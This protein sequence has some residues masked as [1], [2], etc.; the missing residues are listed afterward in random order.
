[1]Q[2]RFLCTPPCSSLVSLV[3][4]VSCVI[5]SPQPL[6]DYILWPCMLHTS[7]KDLTAPALPLPLL[8]VCLSRLGLTGVVH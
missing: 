2:L 6:K 3:N 1:M 7:T 4:V 8:P 5:L